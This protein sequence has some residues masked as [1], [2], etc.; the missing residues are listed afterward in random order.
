MVGVFPSS[1]SSALRVFEN[2]MFELSCPSADL[3]FSPLHDAFFF[4]RPLS[5]QSSNAF[6]LVL[7]PPFV[8]SNPYLGIYVGAGL[9]GHS[10]PLCPP[11]PWPKL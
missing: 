9:T 1:R 10:F 4:P 11:A 8:G 6:S 7:P 3:H 2:K 5:S